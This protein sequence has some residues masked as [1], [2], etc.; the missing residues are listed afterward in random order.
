MPR[1]KSAKKHQRQA[2]LRTATNRSQRSALRSAVKAARSASSPEQQAEALK[3]AERLLDR[4]GQ[5]RLI[6][7]NT[8]ARLKSRLAKKS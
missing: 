6:H 8:A 5:K 4:A 1:T 7:P 2:K 3:R